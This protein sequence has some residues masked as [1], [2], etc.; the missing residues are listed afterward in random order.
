MVVVGLGLSSI[1]CPW[2][3]GKT[4]QHQRPISRRRQEE[5]QVVCMGE[6]HQ[7]RMSEKLGCTMETQV[8]QN[9]CLVEE[10]QHI[11]GD[12]PERASSVRERDRGGCQALWDRRGR[13]VA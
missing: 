9:Q 7:D 11:R 2:V 6:Q 12:S 3:E 1:R 10:A 5:V 8:A 4:S 13:G